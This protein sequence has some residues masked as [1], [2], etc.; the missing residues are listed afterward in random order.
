M[1]NASAHQ[2]FAALTVGGAFLGKEVADGEQSAKPVVSTVLAG[3]LG[4]LP[5]KIEPALHPHHRQFYHSVTLGVGV[6]WLGRQVYKWRP[7][8]E[9]GEI[10]RFLLLVAGGAYLSH[11][12]LDA[13]TKRSLPLVGKFN[14]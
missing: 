13:L 9:L 11:L 2:M 6:W 8:S 3:I 4:T 14:A 7:E 12:A 1:P 5:D 10:A